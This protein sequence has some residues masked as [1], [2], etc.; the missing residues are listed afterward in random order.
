M[1]K[2]KRDLWLLS[3]S[4]ALPLLQNYDHSPAQPTFSEV[5]IL[6]MFLKSPSNS[7]SF[8]LSPHPIGKQYQS[9]T[10]DKDHVHILSIWMNALNQQLSFD[11]SLASNSYLHITP[12]LQQRAKAR[13]HWYICT[14]PLL[15]QASKG[16][17]ISPCFLPGT[18]QE[19]VQQYFV[20]PKICFQYQ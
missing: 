9:S 19:H 15:S 14:F 4:S 11:V 7:V 18:R 10:K 1:G 16:D 20:F 13:T 17:P 2:G 8:S 6:V 12:S 5:F 3:A